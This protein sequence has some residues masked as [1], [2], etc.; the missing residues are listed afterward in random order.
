M[1]YVYLLLMQTHTLGIYHE[2]HSNNPIGPIVWNWNPSTFAK[3]CLY[4]CVLLYYVCVL[5]CP[6]IIST[7]AQKTIYV[8]Q[9]KCFLLKPLTLLWLKH[10]DLNGYY[11]TY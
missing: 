11:T 3:I 4:G 7:P 9:I 10:K 5:Q 6:F 1:S 8:S 2:S